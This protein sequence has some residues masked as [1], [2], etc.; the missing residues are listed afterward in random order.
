MPCEAI[1][2]RLWVK[3][4]Y[5]KIILKLLESDNHERR[6]LVSTSPTLFTRPFFFQFANSAN[7]ESVLFFDFFTQSK[8]LKYFLNDIP[9]VVHRFLVPFEDAERHSGSQHKRLH[10]GFVLLS[11]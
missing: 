4:L 1:L 8:S 11:R 10:K 2:G 7:R 3:N 6:R 9:A 5:Q